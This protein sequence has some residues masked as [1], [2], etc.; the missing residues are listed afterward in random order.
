MLRRLSR[1]GCA[2]LRGLVL[3]FLLAGLIGARPAGAASAGAVPP[4]ITPDLALSRLLASVR[5]DMATFCVRPVDRLQAILCAGTIRVGV[6]DNYPPF[7]FVQDSRPSG[8]EIAIGQRIARALGVTLALVTVTPADRIALLAENRV[9]LTIATMGDTT[10]RDTQARFIRP[11]Y[12]ASQTADPG[13]ARRAAEDAG[14][15]GRPHH[16]RD[17]RR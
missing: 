4:E 6:R 7:G 11:H 17:R 5:H 12:Y 14:G 1:R 2:L 16:L 3:L 15:H 8:F 9:D 13:A 10:L